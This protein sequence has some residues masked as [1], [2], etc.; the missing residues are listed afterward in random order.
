MFQLNNR[1]SRPIYEQMK[2]QLRRLII[3]NVIQS[4]EKLPSIREIASTLAINPNTMQRA[5]REL[6][7][8]GYIYTI[9]GKGSFA[10][11]KQDIDKRR[12]NELLEQFDNIVM[13]LHYIGYDEGYLKDRI[14]KQLSP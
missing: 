6:E 13:E 4:D 12:E 9:P 3:T 5:Y 7:N 2:E 11:P 1:D 10:S 8:E 14:E